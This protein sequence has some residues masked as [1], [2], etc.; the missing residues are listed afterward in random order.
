MKNTSAKGHFERER[1]FLERAL[2]ATNNGNS[3][4]YQSISDTKE[5]HDFYQKSYSITYDEFR[6]MLYEN[7]GNLLETM[8]E[9]EVSALL[10]NAQWIKRMMF[11]FAAAWVLSIIILIILYVIGFS[12]IHEMPQY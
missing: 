8:H 10:Q 4:S 2:Y 1:K 9:S 3:Q 5:L 6:K 11:F 12:Q 7:Y